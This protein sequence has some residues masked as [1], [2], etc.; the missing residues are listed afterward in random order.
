MKR[1]LK[2]LQKAP[3]AWLGTADAF[4]ST[5]FH[6]YTEHTRELDVVA[7]FLKRRGRVTTR[8]PFALCPARAN[9]R[10]DR[11]NVAAEYHNL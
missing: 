3:P 9:E 7:V 4:V 5:A 2:I 8:C 10:V 1:R 11:L 6:M